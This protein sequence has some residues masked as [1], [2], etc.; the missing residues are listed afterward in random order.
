M[1]TIPYGSYSG[2]SYNFPGTRS[3]PGA[4]LG[5]DEVGGSVAGTSELADDSGSSVRED[6]VVGGRVG[7]L[8]VEFD[9]GGFT[10]GRVEFSELAIVG[11]PE[12]SGA[13]LPGSVPVPA[14]VPDAVL[15]PS[16]IS[17][18][19]GLVIEVAGLASSV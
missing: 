10:S 13:V 3:Y 1:S 5:V 12:L 19:D 15:V 2:S 11:P 4:E 14:D 8:E 18:E 16:T 9:T 6:S 7:A 17:S